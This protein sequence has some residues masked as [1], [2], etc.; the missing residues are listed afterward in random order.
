[1]PFLQQ[2]HEQVDEIWGGFQKGI[3][4]PNV[5]MVRQDSC[6]GEAFAFV[7]PSKL[8]E[9]KTNKFIRTFLDSPQHLPPDAAS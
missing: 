9:A 3:L 4:V 8:R 7:H 2:V 1:M 6:R 5:G